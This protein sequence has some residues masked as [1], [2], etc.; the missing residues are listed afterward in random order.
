MPPRYLERFLE[1]DESLPVPDAVFGFE[2][3]EEMPRPAIVHEMH[4]DLIA[5]FQIEFGRAG[6][7]EVRMEDF[8][9]IHEDGGVIVD[10]D[11]EMAVDG[12][13][14]ELGSELGIG[15]RE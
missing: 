15:R 2:D 8:V 9:S 5:D 1:E 10:I 11:E 3:E 14:A 6:A 4:D 7:A 12:L 13:L